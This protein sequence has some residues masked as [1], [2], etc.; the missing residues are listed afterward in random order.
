MYIY[1]YIY[2]NSLNTVQ[3]GRTTMLNLNIILWFASYMGLIKTIMMKK[4]YKH[5]API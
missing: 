3:I 4:H 5:L 2:S 1:I